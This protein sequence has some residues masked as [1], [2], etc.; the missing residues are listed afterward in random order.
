MS[1]IDGLRGYYYQILGGLL[2]S[3]VDDSWESIKIEPS[4]DGDKVDIEWFYSNKIRVEQ[5]KSSINN[6]ERS[7]VVNWIL[8]LVKDARSAYE[9]FGL[10]I[11]FTLYLI[12]T[13]DKNADNWISDL[14]GGRLEIQEGSKLK[15]IEKD[16]PSVN[17]KK[18]SFDFDSFE[19]LAYVGMHEYLERNGKMAKHENI[20]TLCSV[21]VSELL[22]FTLQKRPMT[23]TLFLQLIN[24]HIDSR[25]YG[26]TPSLKPSP[27][28][29]IAFYEKEKV[30]EGEEMVGIQLD[31]TPL[32]DRFL[33]ESKKDL[34]KAKS[35]KLP[36]P[37][38]EVKTDLKKDEESKDKQDVTVG[39]E[40]IKLAP[41]L[42]GSLKEFSS[43]GKTLGDLFKGTQ[44]ITKDGYIPVRMTKEEVEELKTLSNR[45]L[46]IVLTEDD[47]YFGGL[48]KRIAPAQ[49]MFGGPVNVPRGTDDEK[50]KYFAI[51]RAYSN[52]LSYQLILEYTAYLKTCYPIP[53]VLI[54]TGAIAD[55]EIRVT[56]TFPET[57]KIVTPKRMKAPF[58]PFIEDFITDEE[59]LD[60][61]IIPKREHNVMEYV[62]IWSKMPVL[63]K[64]LLPYETVKYSDKDFADHL[65]YLF[66]YEHFQI[67]NQ[68]VIQYEF[69]TLNPSLK[70][71]F[72]T[73]LLVQTNRNMDI[74]YM[75]TS[76][77]LSNPING[78][79]HWLH[80]E[81]I[82]L[83]N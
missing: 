16:L 62:G 52:L 80:P 27:Q 56:L 39:K 63:P 11:S 40:P 6:F 8:E 61:L 48:E 15:E 22:K 37:E 46:G 21:I 36:L 72:P 70:M 74:S 43:F 19:A 23:K 14:H 49:R 55:E 82:N 59:I 51:N 50:A 10:P 77:H 13:T 66:S 24:K 78:M 17:V 47:F 81:N 75:I 12:G 76:K 67:G 32:L 34:L 53:F 38:Q 25:E 54:N 71:A 1:G 9:M 65:E 42:S 60:K 30:P 83:S 31:N 45:I 41:E 33:I 18:Q 35:I 20:K 7:M 5:V 58:E 69:K 57:A 73:F 4:T 2:G 28:L 79:L 29:S 3:T 26:I 64:V 68:D 44:L